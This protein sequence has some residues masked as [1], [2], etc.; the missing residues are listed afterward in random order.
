M[1]EFI[2]YFDSDEYI[3]R[4]DTDTLE[5]TPDLEP[6]VAVLKYLGPAAWGSLRAEEKAREKRSLF[7][8]FRRR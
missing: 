6:Q 3:H 8:R 5:I 4:Y 1:E 7:S 2:K